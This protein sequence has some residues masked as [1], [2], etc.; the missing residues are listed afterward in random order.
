MLYYLAIY[1]VTF[2]EKMKVLE[3]AGI[4]AFY[5]RRFFQKFLEGHLKD[6]QPEPT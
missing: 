3:N 6:R 4:Q 5:E 1:L 2:K